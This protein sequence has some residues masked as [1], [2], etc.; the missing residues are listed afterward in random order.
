MGILTKEQILA[1]RGK[2]ATAIVDTP[3]WGGEVIIIALSGKERDAFEA[4]MVSM[5]ANGKQ[6]MNLRNVRAKLVG[7][8]IADPVDFDLEVENGVTISAKLKEGHT[9]HRMFN[10]VE[11]NDLGDVDALTL[12]KVF[13]Q[14]Q[15][16]SGITKDDVEELVGDLKNVKSGVSGSN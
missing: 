11:V 4:D 9:P 1:A 6:S 10:D 14:S 16:L 2:R 12:Q 5:G 8:T 7:R 15:K 13:E 3:A